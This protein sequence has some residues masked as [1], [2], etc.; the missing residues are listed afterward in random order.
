MVTRLFTNV[1]SRILDVAPVAIRVWYAMRALDVCGSGRVKFLV[2]DLAASLRVSVPTLKRYLRQALGLGYLRSLCKHQQTV[3]V[4]YASLFDVALRLG[5][6]DLGAISEIDIGV[7]NRSYIKA[8]ATQLDAER[9]QR[10][11]MHLAR[12]DTPRAQ[13]GRILNPNQILAPQSPSSHCSRGE[14]VVFVGRRCLFVDADVI[15]VGVSQ[16][17]LAERSQRSISTIQRRL[18]NKH[19][20]KHDLPRLLKRQVARKLDQETTFELKQLGRSSIVTAKGRSIFFQCGSAF[21]SGCSIYRTEF[22][23]RS[24]RF[25]RSRFKQELAAIAASLAEIGLEEFELEETRLKFGDE[26]LN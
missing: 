25:L 8:V 18:S 3:E 7:L 6:E 22:D 13:R 20:A 17:Y 24:A 14:N 12:R 9:Y 10:A 15:P 19:R 5:I 16:D 11:S 1:H 21:E 4:Y 23:L 26:N 2:P